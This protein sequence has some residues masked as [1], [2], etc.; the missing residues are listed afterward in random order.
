M[1]DDRTLERAARSWLEEGPTRAPD[2]AVDAALSR[3]TTTRQERDLRIPWRLP[4][5]NPIARLAGAGVLAAVA[6]AVVLLAL[7]PGTLGPGTLTG[8]PTPA[9]SGSPS[10]APTGI[11]PPIPDGTYETSIAVATILSQLDA[12]TKLTAPEKNDIIDQ[13]LHIRGATTLHV[14]ITV[15]GATFTVGYA[16]D[17][18]P[19]SAE[20]AWTLYVLDASTI[21]VDIGTDSSGIQAYKVTRF[22]DTFTL[23]AK[24]PA[25]P[26]EAFVRSALLESAPFAPIP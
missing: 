22:G 19:I 3:I 4:T 20:D 11:E 5:M 17:A 2:H 18:D 15:A 9:I 6:V 23:A 16:S 1:T 7:R 13:L 24:S 8:S 10:A 25:E 12:E 26:V 14:Q 21:A